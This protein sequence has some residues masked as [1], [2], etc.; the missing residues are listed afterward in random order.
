ML[1]VAICLETY[2]GFGNEV[3]G[4]ATLASLSWGLPFTPSGADNVCRCG[5]NLRCGLT[6]IPTS[7]TQMWVGDAM[8]ATDRRLRQLLV[9]FGE[10]QS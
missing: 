6:Y 1:K 8:G 2:V 3:C 9:L 7:H 10:A 4:L 5:I